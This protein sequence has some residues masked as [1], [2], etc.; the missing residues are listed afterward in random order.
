VFLGHVFG[1]CINLTTINL[2]ANLE[3]IGGKAFMNCG[4]LV[5]LTIPSSLTSVKFTSDMMGDR[6]AFINCKKLPIKTRQKLES[7]GYTSGF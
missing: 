3:E 1:D 4:E 6:Y 2:P 5:N 7:L